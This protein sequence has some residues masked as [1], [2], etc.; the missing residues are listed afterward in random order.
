MQGR[1]VTAAR[2]IGAHG[3][4]PGR[5]AAI[6]KDSSAAAPR[7]S[8]PLLAGIT[9]FLLLL[10][11][12][13]TVSG[14]VLS[15]ARVFFL[16]ATPILLIRLLR[17]RYGPLVPADKLMIGFVSW[18]TLSMFVIHE[19]RVAIT[20]AGSTIILLLGGYLC[21]RASIRTK[22]DFIGFIKLF[23]AA[24]MLSIPFALFEA[25]TGRAVWI[26]MLTKIPGITVNGQYAQEPR[27]GLDRVQFAFVHPIHYG[28]FCSIGLSLVYVGLQ[29]TM[30]WAKRTWK[31]ALIGFAAFL[32]LSS[33]PLL[34]MM[35]QVGLI[36]YDRITTQV[37]N[38]WK[39]FGYM[40]LF[41]YIVLELS[42]NRWGI[43][44]LAERLAFNSWTAFNR[45]MLLE[46]GL[47]QIGQTP[48]FGVGLNEWALPP[49]MSGSVDNY[50]LLLAV[51]FGLP[52]F[53][54]FAGAV[55]VSMIGIGRRD[56]SSDQDLVALRRGWIFTMA[57]MCLAIFTVAVWDNMSSLVV[58]AF[59]SGIWMASVPLAE[60][61]VAA[62]GVAGKG[63]R[64]RFQPPHQR[65]VR[66]PRAAAY[67]RSAYP[68]K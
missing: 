18:V 64:R 46:Y 1:P 23:A 27:W 66:E 44:A 42:T 6:D 48:I 16:G 37:K 15:P 30:S 45:R 60:Q 34:A 4:R 20:Y 11:V 59:G 8:L 22:H 40:S 2:G 65:P 58:L 26:E 33:G 50:W 55:L 32:S 54:L 13:F 51:N 67:R 41:G 38:R 28:L 3:L 19:P 57:S 39:I 17:G 12:A 53:L 21:A 35:T 63:P 14:L 25:L 7:R 29:T 52:A 10:P 47:R 36:G 68:G 9:L 31:T 43:Y 62:G 56:F 61:P 5:R 24:V 49:W